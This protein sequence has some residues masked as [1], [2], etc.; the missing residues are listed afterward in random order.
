MK[1]NLIF[2]ILILVAVGLFVSGCGTPKE[3]PAKVN[4][5]ADQPKASEKLKVAFIYVGPVGDAGW[6]FAHDE[7]RKELVK[8]LGDKVETTFVASVPEGADSERV[9]TD[10]CEKGNKVIFATSFGYMDAVIKVAAK[11]PDVTFMHC[12]GNKTAPNVG[13]YFGRMYQARYLSGIIAGKMTKTNLIG[14]VA[15]MPIPEVVRMANAFTLGAQSVNPKA[16]VKVVWTNTWYDPAKEKEAGK[17]LVEAGVDIMAQH[18]DTPGPIQAADDAGIYSIGYNVDMSRFAPKT[19]LTSPVWNWGP[20]YTQVIQS[21]LDKTWKS[22]QYWGPMS[23]GIVGLAPISDKVPA[24]V[25]KLVADKKAEIESGKLNVFAGPL[26]D[27]DGKE[28]VAAGQAMDDQKLLSFDW[29]V[30]GIDGTI[31]K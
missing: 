12:S 19:N 6:S 5:Q 13:T 4:P 2:L 11:Y 21:V 10:L 26:K 29:F 17:S 23:D 1:K 25:Q 31:P 15:A 27:N 3:G 7:G 22:E 24:D 14:Y 16:K 30:Q 9:L 18:Q 20:Y 8:N 28:R